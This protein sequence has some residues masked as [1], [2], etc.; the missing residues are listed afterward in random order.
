[1]LYEFLQSNREALIALCGAKT[2]QRCAPS[3]AGA[4]LPN[5]IRIF[6]QQLIDMLRLGADAD[7][8]NR[9]GWIS[10]FSRAANAQTLEEID[11]A[12]AKHGAALL[13][14]G[15]SVD[16]V[17]HDY[18]DLCQAI[19]ELAWTKKV[20]ISAGNFRTLNRCLDNAIAGAV[21]EYAHQRDMLIFREDAEA[22]HERLGH[23]ADELRAQVDSAMLAASAIKS[24]GVG[25]AGATGAALD[26][27][28]ERMRN[29]IDRSLAE[30]RL[31]AGM[32]TRLERIA[33]ADLISEIRVLGEHEAKVKGCT[34]AVGGVDRDLAVRADRALL[35]SAVGKLLRSALKHTPPKGEVL[36]RTRAT[37]TRV[38]IDIEDQCGGLPPEDGASLEQRAADRRRSDH[39][40]EMRAAEAA[41]GRLRLRNSPGRGCVFT[42]ELPRQC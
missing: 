15:F 28:L 5:G 21:E 41:G 3:P 20:P 39:A 22:M 7:P 11:A 34:L 31:S 1:V 26:R 9:R 32:T 17:V 37:V 10:D 19:T 27:S 13:A 36:L 25:A 40:L 29:I 4:E 6:M 12:A 33:V 30:I 23:L 38:G 8:A 42:I 16:Q 24:G 14:H 2:A 35:S 18:G